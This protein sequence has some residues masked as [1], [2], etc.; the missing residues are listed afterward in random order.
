MRLLTTL[1]T[2]SAAVAVLAPAAAAQPCRAPDSGW[3]SCMRGNFTVSDDGSARAAEVVVKLTERRDCEAN[4]PRRR[5]TLLLDGVAP[6]ERSRRREARSCRNGV[7][8]WKAKLREPED[9]PWGLRAGD[10]LHA[11]WSRLDDKSD[12]AKVVI[13]DASIDD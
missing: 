10:E 8:R 13:S 2:V 9:R 3:L 5:V 4:L 6:V 11:D 1:L 12:R 7:A